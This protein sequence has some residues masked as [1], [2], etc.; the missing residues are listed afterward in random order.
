MQPQMFT[1]LGE[2]VIHWSRI[3]SG[4]DQEISTMRQYPIV[5]KL[6]GVVPHTFGKKLELWRRSVRTLYPTIEA[7][8]SYADA[9]DEAAKKVAKF[10]NHLI[11]GT[12]T[13][14]ENDEG[15]FLVTNYRSVRGVARHDTLWVGQEVLD[16][17]L[18]DVRNLSAWITGFTVTKMLHAHEGLL[19]AQPASSPD[20]PVHPSPA[21]PETPQDQPPPS[22]D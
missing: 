15:E 19:R 10:R 11:H 4:I 1:T 2:V 18:H 14:S 12:W 5:R 21:T 3:E 9:F 20:H 7:Y 16:N 6:A 17:L 22:D 8:Q 13:L